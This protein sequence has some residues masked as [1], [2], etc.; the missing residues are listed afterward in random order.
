VAR[1]VSIEDWD[2]PEGLELLRKWAGLDLGEI[3]RRMGITRTTLSR[4]CK[5]SDAIR[6]VLYDRE[7]CEAVEKEVYASC[8]D[9]SRTVTYSEQVLDKNGNVQTLTKEK[10]VVL[11]ADFRAQKY[12]LNNRNPERW[13]EK[14]EVSVDAVSGGMVT[15][16]VAEMIGEGGGDGKDGSDG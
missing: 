9:R 16:P 11:P 14:M 12:W 1:G 13:K 6:A 15:L 5:K 2:C 10:V 4:W 3:A 7:M 8:F